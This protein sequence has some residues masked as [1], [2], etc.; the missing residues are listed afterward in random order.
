M[1]EIL[2]LTGIIM[3]VPVAFFVYRVLNKSTKIENS[4]QLMSR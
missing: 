1:D 4:K 3:L 2:L